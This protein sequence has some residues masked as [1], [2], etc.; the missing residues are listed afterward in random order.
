MSNAIKFS[1][2]VVAASFL[3]EGVCN[4]QE[5]SQANCLYAIEVFVMKTPQN[6]CEPGIHCFEAYTEGGE[7][8]FRKNPE[9]YGLDFDEAWWFG[10]YPEFR[11][12]LIYL[13]I[14]SNRRTGDPD[15]SV[16]ATLVVDFIIGDSNHL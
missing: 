16:T 6:M 4:A 15:E 1:I 5:A 10:A 7:R 14:P 8:R 13:L 9:K 11:R 2:L 12:A 3:T